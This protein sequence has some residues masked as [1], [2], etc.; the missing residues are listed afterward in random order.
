MSNSLQDLES[1]LIDLES[2]L[3]FQDDTIEKL[4]SVVTQQQVQLDHLNLQV[5]KLQEWIKNLQPSNI[6]SS[7]EE[8]PPP[9]Y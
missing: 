5:E 1:K 4:N 2:K 3:A 6:A 8:T 9:H 7:S